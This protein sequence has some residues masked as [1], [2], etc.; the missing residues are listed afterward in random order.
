MSEDVQVTLP[1]TPRVTFE[2]N[3]CAP[4]SGSIANRWHGDLRVEFISTGVKDFS[5]DAGDPA[6]MAPGMK[7]RAWSGL[8][9]MGVE[10]EFDVRDILDAIAVQL[11]CHIV[12]KGAGL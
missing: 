2:R 4:K 12:V 11:D 7:L 10:G 6:D 3:E 8:T 9:D 5:D 1:N